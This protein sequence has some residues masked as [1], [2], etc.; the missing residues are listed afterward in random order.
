MVNLQSP[1]LF[2]TL[3]NNK[4]NRLFTKKDTFKKL[5]I[6]FYLSEIIHSCSEYFQFTGT[7]QMQ[8]IHYVRFT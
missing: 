1:Q 3:H 6:Y 5:S 8:Y 4:Y 2:I 7:R